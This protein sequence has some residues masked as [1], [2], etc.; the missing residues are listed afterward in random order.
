M[1]ESFIYMWYYHTLSLNKMDEWT[2]KQDP[3]KINTDRYVIKLMCVW[4]RFVCM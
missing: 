1:Y 3:L 4:I 2:N